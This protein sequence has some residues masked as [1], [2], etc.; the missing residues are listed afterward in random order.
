MKSCFHDAHMIAVYAYMYVN[1]KKNISVSMGRITHVAQAPKWHLS[2]LVYI[3]N[4]LVFRVA[5]AETVRYCPTCTDYC[6]CIVQAIQL[7]AYKH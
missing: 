4:G 2:S 1:A 7:S 3:H 5:H 6:Q